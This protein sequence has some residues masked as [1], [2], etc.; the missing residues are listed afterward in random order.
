MKKGHNRVGGIAIDQLKSI[1][2]RI[3]KLS[4]EKEGIAA[5]IRDV[6]AEARGNGW[7]LKAIRTILK[8]RKQDAAEREEQETVLDTYLHAL[9]MVPQF[10]LF[11]EDEQQETAAIAAPEE[12]SSDEE[13]YKQAVVIVVRDRKAS[14]SYLQRM[15]KTGYNRAAQMIEQMEDEGIVGPANHIGKREVLREPGGD[16]A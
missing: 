14:S 13:M 8:M 3:E 12:L 2:A 7:D 10:D 6:L 11:D 16:V 4:E 15:L 5:D 1:I 9:G